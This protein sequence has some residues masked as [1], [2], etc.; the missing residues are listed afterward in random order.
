ME[1]Q[2]PSSSG[3]R[4]EALRA[5]D[6]IRQ[7]I[8]TLELAPGAPIHEPQLAADLE[9]PLAAVRAALKLLAHEHLVVITPRYGAYVASL[10]V[11]DLDQLSELRVELESL[12]AGLAAQRATPVDLA[13]LDAIRREQLAAGP[14]DLR[15][16][17]DIDHG[18]HRAIAAAARNRHLAQALRR[19]S[20]FRCAC[21]T[22]PFVLPAAAPG[23]VWNSLTRRW[24]NTSTWWT[25]SV[26]ATC[27]TPK[28]SCEPTWQASTP[29]CAR[30]CVRP[31]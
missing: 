3:S 21:G 17:F 2:H 15:K 23:R 5:Y 28:P 22:W 30:R 19:S 12:A 14:A 8:T 27:L 9:A 10:N 31:R 26:A 7:R 24:K 25:P 16:L 6:M 13:A 29:A 18:F 11:A 20:A 1:I 4:A